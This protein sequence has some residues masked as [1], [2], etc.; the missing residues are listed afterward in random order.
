MVVI[1]AYCPG[2]TSSTSMG[3]SASIS[4][5]SLQLNSAPTKWSASSTTSPLSHISSTIACASSLVAASTVM[6]F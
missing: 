5:P 6:D 3:L 1:L 2:S 4:C